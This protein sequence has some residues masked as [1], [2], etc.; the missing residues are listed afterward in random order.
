MNNISQALLR[1]SL[2]A[3]FLWFGWQ[4]LANPSSWAVFL[5]SWTGY[6]PIPTEM[7]IRLN[8]WLEI[9]GA[10][11][12]ILGAFT[13]VVAGILALHLLA[14]AISIG[15]SIGVRDGALALACLA[16]A[17]SAPDKWTLDQTIK[18]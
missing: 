3:L 6:F 10:L 5:P 2:A 14:I 13:R 16:L 7:L 12:L 11:F 15:G 17:L 9:I 8:G 18:K 1:Y 4:Q